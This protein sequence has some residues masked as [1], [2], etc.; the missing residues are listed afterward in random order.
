MKIIIYKKVLNKKWVCMKKK[1]RNKLLLLSRGMEYWI[2]TMNSKIEISLYFCAMRNNRIRQHFLEFLF[3]F[4]WHCTLENWDQVFYL[5]LFFLVF[6]FLHLV[7]LNFRL[8][9]FLTNVTS[10]L[11]CFNKI[12]FS[13]S[14]RKYYQDI[15]VFKH[16]SVERIIKE[17]P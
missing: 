13:C 16:I 14:I 8:Y 10:R 11:W 12:M 9:L 2:L 15:L 5:T 3:C 1:I 6:T 17:S 4:L 7:I